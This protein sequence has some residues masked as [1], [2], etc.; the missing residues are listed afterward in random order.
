VRVVDAV[1]SAAV[2]SRIETV[3]RVGAVEGEGAGEAQIVP[4]ILQTQGG[5]KLA[6]FPQ[7]VDHLPIGAD[8]G[9]TP[10]RPRPI[11]DIPDE[12]HEEPGIRPA[13]HH[14]AG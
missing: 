2:R 8:S 1:E 9:I 12:R 4:Q 14:E 3:H 6:L 11:D 13:V 10:A 5:G 7:E